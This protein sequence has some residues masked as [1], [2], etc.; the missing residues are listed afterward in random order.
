MRTPRSLSSLLLILGAVALLASPLSSSALAASAK[1]ATTATKAAGK[2]KAGKPNKARSEAAKKGWET[3]RM[4][5]K[6][7][8]NWASRLKKN[9]GADVPGAK[10]TFLKQSVSSQRGWKTRQENMASKAS[11][12]TAKTGKAKAGKKVAAKTDKKVAAKT[13]KKVAA[14][15][16]KKVAAKTDKKGKKGKKATGGKKKAAAGKKDDGAAATPKIDP[17]VEMIQNAGV[18][19]ENFM[20]SLAKFDE[21]RSL[22]DQPGQEQ[23][24]AE[25]QM[26]GHDKMAQAAFDTANAYEAAGRAEEAGK[27]REFGMEHLSRADAIELAINSA[28]QREPGPLKRFFSFINPFKKRGGGDEQ[29]RLASEN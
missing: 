28:T 20:I 6:A 29:A 22:K 7:E 9:P 8:A 25:A 2:T 24:A 16:G 23:A 11:A 15:T 21:S 17:R 3:R 14:K 19:N 13:D 1:Q 5:Q 4:N 27:L 26:D 12:K 10:E 18:G